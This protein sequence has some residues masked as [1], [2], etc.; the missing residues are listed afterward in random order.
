MSHFPEVQAVRGIAQADRHRDGAV[1]GEESGQ[2]DQDRCLAR[3]HAT[4]Q[5]VRPAGVGVVYILHDHPAQ[6]V[7]ADDLTDIWRGRLDQLVRLGLRLPDDRRR[8]AAEPEEEEYRRGQG[9]RKERYEEPDLGAAGRTV[10]AAAIIEV[11]QRPRAEEHDDKGPHHDGDK[12]YR[13]EVGRDLEDRHRESPAAPASRRPG[14]P[15]GRLAHG[16]R[17]PDA[18]KWLFEKG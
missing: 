2:L 3:A 12:D 6:L 1:F 9:H 4:D 13:T 8:H 16:T 11:G 15:P 5:Q 18:D 7:A 14:T 10:R 17:A